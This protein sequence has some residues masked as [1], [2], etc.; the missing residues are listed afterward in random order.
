MRP[1]FGL[2][3]WQRRGRL[4]VPRLPVEYATISD[5]QRTFGLQGW[6]R[7]EGL[8]YSNERDS[9]APSDIHPSDKTICLVLGIC[10]DDK[11]H[12]ARSGQCIPI[13]KRCDAMYDCALGEDEVDCRKY[14]A[15]NC[16]KRWRWLTA[17]FISVALT[18]GDYMNLDSNNRS[19][20]RMEGIFTGYYDGAWHVQCIQ[21]EMMKND[22][23]KSAIGRNLCTYLG[24]AYEF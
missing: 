10:K 13:T 16:I 11:F 15:G 21:S 19:A 1:A 14:S 18:D 5:L 3:G 7:R 20:S 2:R 8:R 4:Y 12:C 9:V 23:F 6:N 24:F 17:F 22:T